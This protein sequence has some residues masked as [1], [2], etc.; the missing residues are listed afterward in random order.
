MFPDESGWLSR[1]TSRPQML[2]DYI[3]DETSVTN[4]SEE[5]VQD[6]LMGL[7]TALN[8]DFTL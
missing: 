8:M 3:R 7:I 4:P 5:F 1:M 2:D 6:S